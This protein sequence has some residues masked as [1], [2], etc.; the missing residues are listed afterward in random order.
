MSDVVP[1]QA[2][3]MRE[4][5]ATFREL[6]ART[7]REQIDRLLARAVPHDYLLSILDRWL[8]FPGVHGA[9]DGERLV[10]IERLDDLGQGE[11]WLGAIRVDPE[12]RRKGW[13]HRLSSWSLQVARGMGV[14]TVRLIIEDSNTASRALSRS[15]GFRSVAPISHS[16]GKASIG[17]GLAR[18]LR[19]ARAEEVPETDRLTGVAELNGYLLTTVP[20]PMRFVRASRARLLQELEAGRLFVAGDDPLQGL[21]LLGPPSPSSREAGLTLRLLATL[22]SDHSESLR[23][24]SAAE[25]DPRV[26]FEGF[27]PAR[28]PALAALRAAG[29]QGGEHAIWGEHSQL[30]EVRL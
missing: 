30:Y 24:V 18:P 16:I 1:P 8:S 7:D 9:F 23:S 20:R 28:G 21:F 17:P 15:L 2:A 11:G 26:E 19:P 5:N 3:P 12:E 13:A 25:G 4:G 27:L 22:G 10:A 6:D 14:N 29:W